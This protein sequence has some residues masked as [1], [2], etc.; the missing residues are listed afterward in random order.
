YQYLPGHQPRV[1]ATTPAPRSRTAGRMADLPGVR[2]VVTTVNPTGSASPQ[3]IAAPSHPPAT[4]A[5]LVPTSLTA[6]PL[7]R[8]LQVGAFGN[9]DNAQRLQRR[10]SRELDREVRITQAR[11]VFRVQVGPLQDDGEAERLAL[12]LAD[13]GLPAQRIYD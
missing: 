8:Y 12:Q 10:L 11:E 7:P 4:P 5:R 9:R 2:S 13:R 3:S 6:Q 1:A